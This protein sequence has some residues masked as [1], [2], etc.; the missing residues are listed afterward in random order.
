MLVKKVTAD[1]VCLTDVS[2]LVEITENSLIIAES[3]QNAA[4]KKGRILAHGPDCK[5]VVDGEW[6]VFL[7]TIGNEVL[8]KDQKYLMLREG[9]LFFVANEAELKDLPTQP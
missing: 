4:V 1:R 8:F 7:G 5:T 3:K 2:L 9:D 6:G